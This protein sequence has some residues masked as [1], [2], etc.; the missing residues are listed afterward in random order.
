MN[1]ARFVLFCKSYAGDL[2]RFARLWNSIC[3][4]NREKLP[5]YAS[6]P[7][8]ELELFQKEVGYPPGLVWMTDEEIVNANPPLNTD[9]YRAWDG[10]KSQQVV[11][12]EFWRYVDCDAYLCLD[13]ES[14][15]LRDFG[16]LDFLHSSGAPYTVMHQNK[17]LLQ[18]AADK[19]ISK[20]LRENAAEAD[21][22]RSIFGREGPDYVF[23]PTPVIWAKAVWHDLD[24]RYLEPRGWTLWDAIESFPSE[25]HWYGE[26]LMHFQSIPLQPIGPLFRVYHYNWQW[27]TMQRLGETPEKLKANYLGMLRQSNWDYSRDSG[28]GNR[29]K[30]PASQLLRACKHFLARFR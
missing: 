20:V 15:F 22:G 13:S 25:L 27:H 8:A 4:H 17:E 19:G 16:L 3:K 5:F 21:R 1:S 9:R 26:A 6:V 11:K 30:S 24:K 23:G 28:L 7:A 29:R 10:R 2:L 18:L 14:E 12:S